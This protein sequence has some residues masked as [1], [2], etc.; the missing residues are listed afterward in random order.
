MK[1]IK[2]IFF[3]LLV[4]IIAVTIYVA[5][6]PNQYEFNRSRIIKAPAALLYS[7]VNNYEKWPE[8][9]PWL[10]QE[11]DATLTY[12]N[13]TIGLDANYSWNGE[14]LGEG[15]MKTVAI[16]PNKSITQNINFVKPFESSSKINWTFEATPEGTKVTWAMNGKQDFMTKAY[17]AYS[18]AIEKTT[19]PD[20]ERGLFKLD[21][22][23]LQDMKKYSIKVEGVAE[24]G[25]GFYIYNT[26]SCKISDLPNK[27]AEMMPKLTRYMKKHS[28]TTAGPPYVLYH[29]QDEENGTAMFSCCL[30]TLAR[31]ITT[32]SDILTGKLKS[33]NALTTTLRGDYTNL[34]DAWAKTQDYISKNNLEQ[35]KGGTMLE[36]YV[37]DPNITPNPANYLTDLFIAVKNK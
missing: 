10:E 35:V 36:S 11:P 16:E 25:G 27:I 23:S 7:K 37:T 3:L 26:S 12:G 20:F 2:Y 15:N 1:F 14:I 24:H 31:V 8:F 33:F 6:Q 29:K 28:I 21:S 19:G 30:P 18:G 4:A 9:S 5:V 22:I 13:K 17:T 32:E 34:K